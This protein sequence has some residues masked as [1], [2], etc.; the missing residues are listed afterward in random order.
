MKDSCMRRFLT[1]M[2]LVLVSAVCYAGNDA[3][4]VRQD[5]LLE[6]IGDYSD[7][8]G[9]NVLQIGA[10]GTSA[11]RTIVGAAAVLDNDPDLADAMDV[12]RGIRKIAL[13]D[14]AGCPDDAREGF[15]RRLDKLLENCDILL[16]T[17]DDG[18]VMRLFGVI[19]EKS[20]EVK[21]FILYSPTNCALICLFGR[22]RLDTIAKIVAE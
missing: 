18:G 1:L 2:S 17:K 9:F 4:G 15:D 3:K 7:N 13:V 12:I 10:V 6:L 19:D 21:D 5:R 14:Y 16:E 22:I 11:I 8:E 20:E